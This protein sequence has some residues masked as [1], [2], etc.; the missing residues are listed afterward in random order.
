LKKHETVELPLDTVLELEYADITPA[1]DCSGF[2]DTSELKPRSFASLQLRALN[3][4][5]ALHDHESFRVLLLECGASCDTPALCEEL[6]KFAGFASVT[7]ALCPSAKEL[8]G[9]EGKPG[10]V[11]EPGALVLSCALF[12]DHPKWVLK[13]RAALRENPGLKLMLAGGPGDLAAMDALWPELDSALRADTVAEFSAEG[14][15]ALLGALIAHWAQRQGGRH[16]SAEAVSALCALCSRTAGD[17]RW[18]GL[19][20]ERLKNLLTEAA[21]FEKGAVIS[22]RAL[23]RALGAEDF[24]LNFV[25]KS[26]LRD[27]RD[28]QLL[29]QTEGQE[30][31]QINGLSVIETSGTSY[32]YG[33][34]VRITAAMRAGGDGDVIDIE[35]KAE[36]A[37]Q[38][39]AKAMMI[40]N[41]YL[42]RE[43]GA[44]TPL[45]ASASLVFEQSYSE[46]DGDS[47][48][49]T[50]LCAV[51]S[52]F[53]DLPVRQDLAVT[54][55]V[56]Q[57][58]NVQPVGGVNEKI[59]GFYRICRLRGL[60]GTQGVIIPMS[61]VNQV[62]LR[63]AVADAVKKGRFHLYTVAHVT[64]AMKILTGVPWGDENDENSVYAR[65]ISRLEQ[66][67]SQRAGDHPWWHFW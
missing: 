10:L 2:K 23:L 30:T 3:A 57:L 40:I 25:A 7:L 67:S 4:A 13:L 55:A 16:V 21:S 19:Q 18:I 20:P 28:E 26:E 33:E 39:H 41:G 27:H 46:I 62:L 6:L 36:L 17:R 5:R 52:S 60:T 31:G 65:I 9:A 48:S 58:G 53:A 45:P 12:E 34:P 29:I 47:A 59:E 49:L 38:I 37:G 64:G 22:K 1:F 11:S 15:G 63:P 42:N 24:R 54:G 14:A 44:L 50:G 61:C 32:V 35:R 66:V 51:L 8:F 56:D 43:F